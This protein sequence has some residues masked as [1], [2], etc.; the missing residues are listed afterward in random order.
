MRVTCSQGDV[1]AIQ[2]GLQITVDR[3][4]FEGDTSTPEATPDA[5]EDPGEDTT[6][7][8]EESEAPAA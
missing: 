8:P 6:E 3:P 4:G 7:N 5:T 1:F 2:A